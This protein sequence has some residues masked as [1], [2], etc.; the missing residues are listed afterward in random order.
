MPLSVR[1]VCY[2]SSNI[3]ADRKASTLF[4]D[5]VDGRK[6]FMLSIKED[7]SSQILLKRQKPLRG[8]I[9]RIGDVK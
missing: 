2:N 7:K 3:E 5:S 6:H 1:F 8:D 4:E 9:Q